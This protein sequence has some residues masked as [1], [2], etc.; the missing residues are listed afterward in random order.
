MT[1]PVSSEMR[2][3]WR[4]ALFATGILSLA[5]ALAGGHKTIGP[6]RR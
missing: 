2:G 1:N 3:R 4:L 6:Q 5:T